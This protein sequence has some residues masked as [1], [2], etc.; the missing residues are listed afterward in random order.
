MTGDE[1]TD[2]G[3][4][5][6]P[7]IGQ[8]VPQQ[9]VGAAERSAPSLLPPFL[10]GCLFLHDLVEL[11]PSHLATVGFSFREPY[12][13]SI[14]NGHCPQ[15][16]SVFLYGEFDVGSSQRSFWNVE[17]YFMLRHFCDPFVVYCVA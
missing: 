12:D 3:T 9:T 5:A 10:P 1:R 16:A 8:V 14:G 15:D 2:N 17:C 6:H 7:R 11:T 13:R 4:V